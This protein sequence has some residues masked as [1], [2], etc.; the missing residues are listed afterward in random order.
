LNRG[1]LFVGGVVHGGPEKLGGNEA[2]GV[3]HAV[4]AGVTHVNAGEEV[5]GRARGAFADYAIL[6]GHQ[7][8]RK[9]PRLSWEQAAATPL[10]F[11]T[12]YEAVIQYGRLTKGE[13]MLVTGA[14]AGTGV[15]AIQIAQVVG[16]RS[17][18]TSGS[19]EK[20]AK[21]KVIGLD[22][23]IHTR[24]P[25]FAAAVRDATGGAGADVAVNLV[26]GSMFPEL[27]RSLARKGRLAIVGYVDNQHHADI[28][29]SAVHANRFEVFG[30]SNARATAEERAEATRGF[31]RDILPAIESGQITPVVD[32]V[33]R[34]EELPAAKAH[35]EANAMVGK[36]VVRIS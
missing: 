10:S 13:W 9:P 6:E 14:S 30:V 20:L 31:A 33:F 21:L 27:V 16:A 17:I 26:G 23:G 11:I 35:M 34:F 29:L 12:A 32:K 36:I 18:G 8:L 7:V 15:A 28:D 22:V 19:Q 2:A 5:M 1:E 3:V 4:G 24:A 25:D